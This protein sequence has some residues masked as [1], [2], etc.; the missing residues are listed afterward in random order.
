TS[1]PPATTAPT[2]TAPTTTAPTTTAPTTT[3][4]TTTTSEP[5]ATT[6]TTTDVP[7]EEPVDGNPAIDEAAVLGA[8][9][10]W[11]ER[12]ERVRELQRLLDLSADGVYGA[13]TRAA[14]L[15]ENEARGLATGG[16]PPVPTTTTTTTTEPLVDESAV[17]TA[18]YAFNQRGSDVR[19][20][21]EVLGVGAD[22]HYGPATRAA[23]LAENEARGL[24]TGGIPPVPTTTT[25]T[26]TEPPIDE[27]AVLTAIYAFNQ[28]GSDVRVLQEVLGVGA[29]GHYGPATRAA[30]LAENEARGLATGG[31]PPVPTTTT[32]TTTTTTAPPSTTAVPEE[33]P[34]ETTTTVPDA[35]SGE[36]TTT[37]TAA[38]TTT[39]PSAF[40]GMGA[41]IVAQLL[42]QPCIADGDL[43]DCPPN[44]VELVAGLTG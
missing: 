16:I 3:A 5:P 38:P 39:A 43:S 33:V 25:T 42:G 23:H 10:G 28:R 24:A 36:T 18:I 32:T 13:A 44:V 22:G 14:H 8:E 34:V 30:H 6:T 29:D 37:T 35:S 41:E 2:T 27:S 19:V 4:P 20:L 17:L 40:G 21:Q 7:P 9:Y 11:F 26:T 1:E 12:G 15:A 31:I